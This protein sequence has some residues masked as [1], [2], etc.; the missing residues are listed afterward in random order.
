MSDPFD[1]SK[2]LQGLAKTQSLAPY[3]PYSI[4]NRVYKGET[5]NIDGY[6]FTNCA[7]IRCTLVTANGNFEINQCYLQNCFVLFAGNAQRVMR[8]AGVVATEWQMPDGLR[9]HREDDGAV[10]VK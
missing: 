1:F 7:F 10:T 8:I 2:A 5:L 3:D 4:E 9:P 6:R